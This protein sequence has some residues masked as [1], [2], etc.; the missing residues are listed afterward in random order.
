[1]QDDRRFVSLFSG[2]GGLDL[3]LECAGWEPIAQV[4][5][6]PDAVLTLELAA[7]RRDKSGEAPETLIFGQ[8]IEEISARTLRRNLGLRKGELPLLAGGPP[9]QPFTTH[10]LRLS[11]ND[12]RAAG[13]WP[14]YFDF[15]DEFRPQVLLI[16]NVDG[17]LSAALSHRPIALR[18]KGHPNLE[19]DE[20]K[21]SFLLWVVQMLT[22]RGY[23]VTWGLVEAADYGVAQF[24][25]R[26]ILI[27]TRGNAAMFSAAGRVRSPKPAS[28]STRWPM[29]SRA[30]PG[31]ASSH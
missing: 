21:G 19:P 8:P 16:E 28:L 12:E 24:R 17:M 29:R 11:I 13:V 23:S 9:C 26:A 10:G 15:V 27:A 14:S 7:R 2:P 30:L 3:G 1:M 20:R 6:D 4:E 22:A 5:M 25:Q 31:A 18:S